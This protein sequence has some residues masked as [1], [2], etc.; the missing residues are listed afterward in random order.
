MGCQA[1]AGTGYERRGGN[2]DG[3]RW[4]DPVPSEECPHDARKYGLS[5]DDREHGRSVHPGRQRHDPT[6]RH[7]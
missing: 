6:D 3:V 7:R 5:P 1:L 2:D 4:R